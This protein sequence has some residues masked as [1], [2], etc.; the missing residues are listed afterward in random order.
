VTGAIATVPRVATARPAAIA[1]TRLL[2]WLS[3]A[4]VLAVGAFAID[5]QPVG[6]LRDDAMYV[7]LAKSIATGHGYRWL[8][9]PGTP[10]AIHFP[11]GYPAFLALLWWIAPAFPA[12]VVLFKLANTVLAASSA[13]VVA[14]FARARFA[15]SEW[16][17]QGVALTS[18]VS[19]P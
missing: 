11:P 9:L 16:T 3:G 13:V 5:G 12:S 2:P 19:G 4:A 1:L 7:L 8:N 6:A 10:A 15:M 17:A 14:R 18:A